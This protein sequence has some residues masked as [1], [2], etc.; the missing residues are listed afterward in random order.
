MLADQ[1]SVSFVNNGGFVPKLEVIGPPEQIDRLRG[2]HAD[3]HPRAVLEI[4]RDN[5]DNIN[6][7]PLRI[8][9]LPDDVRVNG[10]N[11]TISFTATR[12]G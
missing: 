8:E 5:V 4:D 1:Y 9:N 6:P 3:Y 7:V 2:P 10:P 12:R 11:P